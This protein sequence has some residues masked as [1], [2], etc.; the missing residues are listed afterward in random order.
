[1]VSF[2]APKLTSLIRSHLII[3]VV[4]SI[5]LG[6]Q[7][8]KTAITSVGECFACVLFWEFTH[9]FFCILL[10]IAFSLA[11][12]SACEFSNFNWLLFIISS[13]LL[14]WSAFVLITLFIYF[15]I[16]TISFLNS[17]S[18]R[19]ERSVSLFVLSGDFSCYSNWE[20]LLCYFILL[21]FLWLYKLQ[22]NCYLLWPWRVVF[23]WEPSCLA[24]KSL[25]FLV[26]GLFLAWMPAMSFLRIC[27]PISP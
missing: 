18:G 1:M 11:I 5:A 6:D 27:R 24:H 22:W 26:Q 21:I 19:L 3:F 15:S 25:I 14:Q 13:S 8:K 9:T 10:F 20:W 4:L 7:P 16:F 17:W 12:V 23:I 2:A